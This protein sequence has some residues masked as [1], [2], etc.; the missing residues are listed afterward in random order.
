MSCRTVTT[1]TSLNYDYDHDYHRGQYPRKGLCHEDMV[2]NYWLKGLTSLHKRLTTQMNQLLRY[3]T[4]PQRLIGEQ[5]WSWRTSRGAK[6]Q[7]VLVLKWFPVTARLDKPTCAPPGVTTKKPMTQCHT[8]GSWN[9]W[10]STSTG[11]YEPKS[12]TPWGHGRQPY[13]QTLIT[14]PMS[15]IK[16]GVYKTEALSPLLVSIGLNPLSHWKVAT[17]CPTA[18][19]RDYQLLPQNGWH[20]L[21]EWERQ[22]LPD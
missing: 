10:N 18:Q 17:D 6:H 14:L 11:F 2:H 7:L 8:H 13:R 3:G 20:Q 19:L 5:P 22:Q 9:V 12:R 16:C 21:F 15:P 4:Q 1:N